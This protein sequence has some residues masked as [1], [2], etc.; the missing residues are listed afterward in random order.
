[1]P[2]TSGYSQSSKDKATM[3][4]QLQFEGLSEEQ[5]MNNLA[6]QNMMEKFFQN[7]FKDLMEP[8]QHKGE[9]GM[10]IDNLGND[11][12]V[13]TRTKNTKNQTI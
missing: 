9:K 7:R 2:G 10:T 6:I 12:T 11:K 8:T 1:M 4:P 5:L 3:V 13:D